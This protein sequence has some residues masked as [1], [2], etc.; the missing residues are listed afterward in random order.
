MPVAERHVVRFESGRPDVRTAHSTGGF[1]VSGTERGDNSLG[2]PPG[3][4]DW[5]SVPLR[6]RTRPVNLC[7]ESCQLW[8]GLGGAVIVARLERGEA[9]DGSV[10]VT[11]RTS[12]VGKGCCDRTKK[13]R[14][15][16]WG[17]GN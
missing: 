11:L 4:G 3:P 6:A 16:T 13:R 5:P 1:V 17:R 14:V 10:V 15:F 7:F 2:P 8:G 12:P 9:G